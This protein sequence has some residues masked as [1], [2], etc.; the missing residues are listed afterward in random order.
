MAREYG[1]RVICAFPRCGEAFFISH[2][3]GDLWTFSS[4][5]EAFRYRGRLQR[6][7]SVGGL[8]G[9]IRSGSSQE[10]LPARCECPK[11]H[12]IF[13]RDEVAFFVAR[14]PEGQ[15]VPAGDFVY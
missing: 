7:S 2:E 12:S 4:V 5:D 15:A 6:Q 13:A 9:R 11:C 3:D 8:S 14:I 10:N 1:I